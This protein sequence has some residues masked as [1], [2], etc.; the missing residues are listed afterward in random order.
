M[1]TELLCLHYLAIVIMRRPKPA[2]RGVN[3]CKKRTNTGRQA[4]NSDRGYFTCV[5]VASR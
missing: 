2:S 3:A 1:E 5:A 4:L